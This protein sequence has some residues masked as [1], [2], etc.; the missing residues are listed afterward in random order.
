MI[1]ETKKDY[2][3]RKILFCQIWYAKD[4][5]YSWPRHP[6]F[7]TCPIKMFLC[8]RI[9]NGLIMHNKK[10]KNLAYTTLMQDAFILIRYFCRFIRTLKV[11]C[12]FWEIIR[13]LNVILISFS[14][15]LIATLVKVAILG[16]VVIIVIIGVL[17]DFFVTNS[18]L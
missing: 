15:F 9:T 12:F 3:Q 1:F 13:A 4:I 17:A 10:E 11:V 14:N 6:W 16:R 2:N 5:I 8:S 18:T 7:F